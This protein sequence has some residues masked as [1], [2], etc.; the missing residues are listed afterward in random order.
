MNKVKIGIVGNGFV[1]KA[2]KLLKCDLVE[3]LVYD[4]RPEACEPPGTTLNDLESCDL[5]FY[6]LPTP[7]NHDSS[8]YTKILEEA[9]PQL[10]NPFKIIRSTVPVGFSQ[11]QTCFFMPEFLTEANWS[12]DFINSTHWIFGL[13]ENLTNNPEIKKLNNKFMEKITQLFTNSQQLG[14]IKS[15]QIYWMSNSEAEFLKLAK[16]CFLAA[17]VGIMN[18]LYQFAQAKGVDYNNIKS[19]LKLDPRIGTTHLNVPG[20]NNLFGYG[21]TC[22]PKDTHSL[23][24]QFQKSDIPSYYF[25]TSLIRNEYMDRK[26]REW[27]TDYWRTTIPTNQTISL[28]TGGAGFIETIFS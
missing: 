18:E 27:A 21:G 1:G 24:S 28:V 17:K 25:Q 20:I 22:F 15:S 14:S 11:S 5:I 23:Y 6:C 10:K 19:M 26:E 8:C 16:N 9:I 13:L 7:I 4:I 3:I 12:S 2:T